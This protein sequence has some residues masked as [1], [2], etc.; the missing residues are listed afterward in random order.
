MGGPELPPLTTFRVI[1]ELSKIDGSVAGRALA[2]PVL[3]HTGMK[4]ALEVAGAVAHLDPP[5]RP[6]EREPQQAPLSRPGAFSAG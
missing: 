5:G 1:E 6:W 2:A 3:S 4:T